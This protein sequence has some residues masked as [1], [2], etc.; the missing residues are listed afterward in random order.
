MVD[1]ELVNASILDLKRQCGG[2]TDNHGLELQV[3]W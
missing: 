1:T 3:S 2:M